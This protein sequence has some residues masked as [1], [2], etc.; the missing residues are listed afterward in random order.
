M[1][2]SNLKLMCWEGYDAA[3]ILTPFE[4]RHN[5]KVQ[6]QT[7]LSDAGTADLLMN[8]NDHRWDV[9]NINNA[10]VRDALHPA[11]K[12]KTLNAEDFGEYREH[13]HEV[14]KTMLPW[15]YDAN[16]NADENDKGNLIGIGQRFGPFNLVVNTN[17]VSK[18]TAEDQGFDLANDPGNAGR[19]AILDYPD[20]NVF[21]F[22]IGAGLNPFDTL[23]ENAIAAFTETARRW[24]GAAKIVSDDHHDLNRRLIQGEIDFYI[25][26]G[27]Y[28]ASPARL[29]G[30]A[31]ILAVT[32]SRGPID[33]KGGIVFSEI[34]SVLNHVH[35]SA[36]A[37]SF[38]HYMLEPETAIAIAFVQGTCNPVAQMGDPAV[39]NG[40]SKIQLDAIQ[41]PGLESDLARCAHYQIPPNNHQLL[42]ILT[43]VKSEH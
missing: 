14:Y 42:D 30:N 19:F 37:E 38:L 43:S 20:F 16:A 25:S 33:G 18:S 11:G 32:P 4:N 35:S 21:Q 24:Y 1:H 41:W 22:C 7:L 12:I 2:N 28:T 29:E 5:I 10:Y 27:I 9:L 17:R 26:G 6:A 3:H 40:F 39:F 36:H 23:D 34:T 13:C 31:N 15:S 8:T